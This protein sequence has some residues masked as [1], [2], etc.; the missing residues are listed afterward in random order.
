LL[1]SEFVPSVFFSPSTSC[2]PIV[3]VRVCSIRFLFSVHILS[4]DCCCPSLF[5]PFS[6]LRPHLV[7]RLLFSEFVPSVFFFPSTSCHPIRSEWK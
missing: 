1:V 2:H 3:G 7:I 6:F 5:R 4:S